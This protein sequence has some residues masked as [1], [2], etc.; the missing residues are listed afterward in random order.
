[1]N[2]GMTG[3]T[4]AFVEKIRFDTKSHPSDQGVFTTITDC[5]F[6]ERRKVFAI[7]VMEAGVFADLPSAN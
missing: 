3:R 1:M 4:A 5:V 2:G 7:N 6:V